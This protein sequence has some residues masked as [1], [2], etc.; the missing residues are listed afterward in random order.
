MT[1]TSPGA[2]LILLLQVLSTWFLVG[3]IWTI[4][5]VHYPLFAAVGEDR[6][7]A[8]EASHTRLITLV[9]GPVMLVEAATAVLLMA[10]RPA[11]F[12][13]WIAWTGL[14]LVILIWI[15][16]AVLQVPDHTKL[17]NGFDATAHAHLV[18]T[19]WLRTIAWTARGALLAIAIW[20]LLRNV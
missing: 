6:F 2:S 9:V 18:G 3:L 7:V 5:V 12:P 15:S 17:A 8:Y 13:A 1:M 11:W 10:A 4:Q 20:P 19:N 16:T 14:A